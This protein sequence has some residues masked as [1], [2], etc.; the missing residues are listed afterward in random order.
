IL[1]SDLQY[2]ISDRRVSVDDGEV[3]VRVLTPATGNHE[4]FPVL[5]WFHGGGWNMGDLDMDDYYLR[6]LCIDFQ[7][8]VV[9]VEY[10]RLVPEHR[11]PTAF[12]DCYAALKWV[13]SKADEFNADVKKG[14]LVGGDSAGGSLAAAVAL[15]ARDDPFFHGRGLTGQFLREP[16]TC[17]PDAYPERFKAELCSF[18]QGKEALLLNSGVMRSY[19]SAYVSP[20]SDLRISPLAAP[21]HAGL[22]PAFIQVQELDP[23][24]DDGVVYEKALRDADVKTRLFL[25]K[26][27]LH[28]FQC[29]FPTL[30]TAVQIDRDGR[31]G[32]R[33]LLDQTSSC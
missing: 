17:H 13:L 27:T 16:A 6:T 4:T 24:R 32:I 20:P 5:V 33:W 30:P 18:A 25:Y 21:T 2:N 26:G 1:L 7:L 22:P 29:F 12:N 10:R 31:E 19:Y 3:T 9:N 23:L 8:A 15:Q 14:F 11:F 28:G